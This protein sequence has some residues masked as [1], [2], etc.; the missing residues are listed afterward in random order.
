MI[1]GKY[2]IAVDA[3]GG[4]NAPA[5]VVAG[6]VEALK[7]QDVLIL[8]VGRDEALSQELRKHDY[9][10]GRIRIISAASII[11]GE[12]NPVSAVKAK[13]DSSMVVGLGLLKSRQAEAFVSAGNTGALLAASTVLV[14]RIKGIERPAIAAVIPT[15]EAPFML[16]DSGANVDCKPSY[17]AQFAKMGAVYMED[18]RGVSKPRVGLVNIGEEREKGNGLVKEAFRLIEADTELNF[19]GNIEARELPFGAVDV[20]VCDGF[21][22]NVVLKH[23]EGLSKALLGMVKKELL[24]SP[25]SKLGALLSKGAFSS[26]RRRFNSDDIGGAPFLGLRALVVKAH[27]SSDASAIAGAINQCVSFIANDIVRKI[28]QRISATAIEEDGC[29]QEGEPFQIGET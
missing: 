17:L 16:L 3:M 20:A 13:K 25:L 7:N 1:D 27:G 4:D 10:K 12:D 18:V 2:V 29:A 5:A 11:T 28:E 15:A 23:T 6:A 21:V 14:G 9:D 8:L 19:V 22:G 26:L 24:A